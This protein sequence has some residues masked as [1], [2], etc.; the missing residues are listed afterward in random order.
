MPNISTKIAD[1]LQKHNI[2][3]LRFEASAKKDVESLFRD[4]GPR[5]VAKIEKYA[6]VGETN[7]TLRNKRLGLLV[8]AVGS[9]ATKAYKELESTTS[10]SYT[11]LAKLETAAAAQA[12]NGVLNVE[13]ASSR[14]TPQR[15]KAV[16]SNVLIEGAPS[17]E[18]WAKQ[19]KEF[20]DAFKFQM[21]L[22][23]V[24][25]E[26]IQQLVQRVRGT[27]ANGFKDGLM[28]TSTRKAQALVRSSVMAVAN[29]ARLELYKE[30]EDVIKGVQWLSTLDSRTTDICKGLDGQAWYNDGRKMPGTTLD[31]RG[32]PPAHWNCRSTMVPVMR[33]WSELAKDPKVRQKLKAAEDKLP[34]GIR[35]SMDG[36][37]SEKLNYE[38]WLKSKPVDF[39]KQVLGPTKWKLWDAGKLS[40]TDFVDQKH[41]PLSLPALEQKVLA[42]TTK[43]IAATAGSA[44]AQKANLALAK[45]LGIRQAV[46]SADKVAQLSAQATL[47]SANKKL[48]T[49]AAKF[50]KANPGATPKQVL[51]GAK[52]IVEKQDASF[53]VSAYKTDALKGKTG[54]TGKKLEA[55]NA[56]D[57]EKQLKLAKDI[58]YTN[59][60]AGKPIDDAVWAVIEKTKGAMEE[61]TSKIAAA[62]NAPVTPAP[63]TG[64]PAWENLKQI[65]PQRGSNPGGMFV[66][67]TTGQKWYVKWPDKEDA[68]RNEALAGK[69][70]AALG[71]EVPELHLIQRNGKTAVASRIVEGLEKT[72]PAKLANAVGAHEGF[73]AD[74]WLA[75]WDVVGLQ[76]DNLLVV[77][78]RAVRVDTGGALLYRAQGGLKGA[79]FG[80][81]VDELNSLRDAKVNAKAASVFGSIEKSVVEAAAKKLAALP[82]DTIVAV[83]MDSGPGDLIQR[84]ALAQKLLKRKQDIIERVLGPA[85]GAQAAAGGAQ[86]AASAQLSSE[87]ASALGK[88][89]QLASDL[90]ASLYKKAPDAW[91]G[92]QNV[93]A[94]KKLLAQ[95]ET[96]LQE[97]GPLIEDQEVLISKYKPMLN[98][99]RKL[100]G[101]ASTAVSKLFPDG[102]I[103]H[104]PPGYVP[105]IKADARL[106]ATV[107]PPAAGVDSKMLAEAF[108]G[109]LNTSLQLY[110]TSKRSEAFDGVED[111]LVA[112][113]RAYTGNHYKKLNTAL[114]NRR[115]TAHTLVIRDAINEA[116]SRAKTKYTGFVKRG[117]VLNGEA[118]D[119]WIAQHVAALKSGQPVRYDSFTST[120]YGSGFSGNV[121]LKIRSKTGVDVDAISAHKGEKEVL[122]RAGTEFHVLEYKVENG[123]HLF[124]LE[125]VGP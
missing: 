11:R 81:T 89:D 44:A 110:S 100:P 99:A 15:L 12:I 120:S 24:N 62:K 124:V 104:V 66:D 94:S 85:G 45:E 27:K 6:P 53:Y 36:A 92:I 51:A 75:N 14:L 93:A 88:L 74:A 21:R 122:F 1:A 61:V 54:L 78:G 86:A 20:T 3:L 113:V 72:V 79:A 91:V 26:T 49:A 17:K 69:L 123:T 38:Q 108:K 39:Q 18:W 101:N 111:H 35:A 37:V 121:R 13:L 80:N 107:A 41:N 73:I 8:Q 105:A 56:L 71:V 25:N 4:L 115:A 7:L 34:D 22:G 30:N 47:D 97:Y 55:F 125:E 109:F 70:Y 68:L 33:S 16:A 76:Y 84:K 60:L 112:A 19:S 50:A 87:L 114:Y 117:I 67:E 106:A 96:L 58:L 57:P 29:T 43:Q 64:A 31:Y 40:F 82:D 90:T 32:P 103:V 119:K 95:W 83:V 52:K 59:G 46:R 63:P 77:A 98:I 10:E 102:I 118:L 23:L 48:T 116:L 28:Q 2:D 42:D 9:D 65:G 5:V